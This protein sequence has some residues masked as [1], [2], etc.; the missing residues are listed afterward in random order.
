MPTMVKKWRC[1]LDL[2]LTVVCHAERSEASECCS[3]VSFLFI[4]VVG[5]CPVTLWS[6]QQQLYMKWFGTLPVGGVAHKSGTTPR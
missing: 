5:V 2:K 3:I 1:L 6:L 4:S